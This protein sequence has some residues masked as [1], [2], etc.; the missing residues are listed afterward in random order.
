MSD[1]ASKLD[2]ECSHLHHELKLVKTQVL[3]G[4]YKV[5]NFDS[6]KRLKYLLQCDDPFTIW[7]W[8]RE[9]DSLRKEL[10]EMRGVL[11]GAQARD[12]LAVRELDKLTKEVCYLLP[13]HDILVTESLTVCCSS[14]LVSSQRHCCY[15]TRIT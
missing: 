13:Q 2:E 14:Q 11:E 4:N 8:S 5:D 9:R 15:M 3:E 7:V 10:D 6:V 1:R 12:Q